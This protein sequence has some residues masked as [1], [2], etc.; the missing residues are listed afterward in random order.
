MRSLFIFS[1]ECNLLI[2]IK[3]GHILKGDVPVFLP[4]K[5]LQSLP[6]SLWRNI[7][8]ARREKCDTTNYQTTLLFSPVIITF[9]PLHL[10]F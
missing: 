4:L 1:I 3:S 10:L 6:R 9:Q 2:S 8:E 5:N 7:K